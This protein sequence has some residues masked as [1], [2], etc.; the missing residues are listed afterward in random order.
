[1]R[2]LVSVRSAA[3]VSPAVAGGADIIDAKD[4]AHGSLGQVGAAELAA[5]ARAAPAGAP[6]SVALG[7][8]CRTD[9]EAAVLEANRRAGDRNAVYLKLGLAGTADVDAA[10][11][12]VSLAVRTARSTGWARVIVVAYAD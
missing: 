5:I 9:V 7:E 4:P 10:A 2:L 1:M 11:Q 12:R 8:L 3:E 6:L